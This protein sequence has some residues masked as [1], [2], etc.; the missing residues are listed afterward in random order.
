MPLM[1]LGSH[2]TCYNR[3]WQLEIAL[4]GRSCKA[5]D[6]RI[7]RQAE[8]RLH[9]VRPNGGR[10]PTVPGEVAEHNRLLQLLVSTPVENVGLRAVLPAHSGWGTI[11]HSA[12]GQ[13]SPHIG[14][15]MHCLSSKE[16]DNMRG[17][18]AA[19][20]PPQAQLRPIVISDRMLA[21]RH[22]TAHTWG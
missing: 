14:A 10:E 22:G 19:R 3:T 13:E 20:S 6:A 12:D 8:Y 21:R 9:V 7:R 17:H 18:S 11:E 5:E 1:P 15:G 16:R 2:R 4:V